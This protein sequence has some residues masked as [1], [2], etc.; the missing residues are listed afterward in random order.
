[1]AQTVYNTS[2]I[3][4]TTTTPKASPESIVALGE[5]IW[6]EVRAA[7]IGPI[8]F[9]KQDEQLKLFQS[10]YK[11]FCVGFPIVIR[12]MVQR[13][14]FNSKVLY[15]YLIRHN[16]KAPIDTQE[17]FL[18]LQAY[19]VSTMYRASHAHAKNADVQIV[20]RNTFEQLLAETKEFE[21]TQKEVDAEVEARAKLN[22]AERKR[23]LVRMMKERRDT[24]LKEQRD[25][26]L[27]LQ[28]VAKGE[29]A[30]EDDVVIVDPDMYKIAENV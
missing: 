13:N 7:K 21:D 3:E 15:K 17:K 14:E 5:Q 28:A 6:K 25:E 27:R 2:N 29:A 19:Y 23:E 11:D 18:E 22:T 24:F 4:A 8:E 20:Y 10:K 12:W 1:M 16:S 9:D 30:A 26:A